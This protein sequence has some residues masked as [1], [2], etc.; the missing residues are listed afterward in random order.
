MTWEPK[1]DPPPTSST[2]VNV[3]VSLPKHLLREDIHITV[4]GRKM[5]FTEWITGVELRLADLG[6]DAGTL[7]RAEYTR[8]GAA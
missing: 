3:W 7:D 1:F 4:D 8:R 5:S 6:Q 2:K